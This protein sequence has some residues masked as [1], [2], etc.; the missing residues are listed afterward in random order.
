MISRT[1]TRAFALT[2]FLLLPFLVSGAI[3]SSQTT[4]PAI[5]VGEN[6]R[7][8][9]QDGARVY[10]DATI[11][12][13]PSRPHNLLMCSTAWSSGGND[14]R[15]AVTYAS[16]DDGRTWTKTFESDPADRPNDPACTMAADGV[17]YHL[18]SPRV[19]DPDGRPKAM[20]VYRSTDAGYHWELVGRVP[21]ID[22]PSITVD[23]T[24]SPYRGR[25]YV[26]GTGYI[27]SIAG[28]PPNRKGLILWRSSDQGHTFIGPVARIFFDRD[29]AYVSSNA[30]VLPDGTWLAGIDQ[31]HN[32]YSSATAAFAAE[33]NV[34]SSTPGHPNVALLVVKSTNGG[35]TLSPGTKVDDWY[36]AVPGKWRGFTSIIP[37]LAAD[38][39]SKAFQNSLYA[40]WPDNRS[41]RAEIRFSY[42]RDAGRTWSRSILVN[43]DQG[44]P[45]SN[46]RNH[47]NP[48]I[49]VNDAGVV[50]IAWYDRRDAEDN[51]GWTVRFTASFDGGETFLPSVPVSSQAQ[52]YRD[53]DPI[54]TTNVIERGSHVTF[55]VKGLGFQ[56]SG[57]AFVGITTNAAGDFFP[58]WTDNRTGVMQAWTAG[59]HINDQA[60]RKIYSKWSSLNDVTTGVAIEL[61]ESSFNLTEGLVTVK[62]RI[63]NQTSEP[64][65]KPI[66]LRAVSLD[67]RSGTP[68]AINSDNGLTGS[69]AAWMFDDTLQGDCL[70]NQERSGTRELRFRLADIRYLNDDYS[71]NDRAAQQDRLGLI[72]FEGRVLAA[73][74]E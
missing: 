7:I 45:G 41:G 30:V 4:N 49:T 29:Y 32:L 53:K 65:C 16:S 71:L 48:M 70:G 3:N 60:V 14:H 68:T 10:A 37:M 18:V 40:V 27:E 50:G 13:H 8:S 66:V 35:E 62:A 43:D 47:L 61:T 21:Y 22:R 20:F 44:A 58:C 6:I 31:L 28:S 5:R 51:L 9:A 59:I 54:F 67:S 12:S 34:P 15:T 36:L 38:T 1:L 64:I 63:L 42:S 55:M 19:F 2:T 17:A 26:H 57:G 11:H 23:S 24:D 74:Q 33:D 69:Y 46:A 39:H 25:V 73:R 56:Y 52:R 72:R